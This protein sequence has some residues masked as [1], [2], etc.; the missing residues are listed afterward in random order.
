MWASTASAVTVDWTFVGNPGNA[1]D[2]QSTGCHGA[3]SYPYF[4]ATY[5]VT[6]AQYAE[7]LN[8]KA[9][10]DPLGLY[11]TQM[12]TAFGGIARTGSAGSYSYAAIPGRE[13]KPVLYITFFDA[14]RFANWLN[15]GQGNASTETGGYTLLSGTPTPGN[16][17]FVQRNVG[18]A[19]IYIASEDE[20]YKA[21]YH[22][23]LGLAETDYFN[24][25]AGSDTRT[26]CAFPPQPGPNTA[27]CWDEVN[28]EFD[29]VDVGS[30]E[31]P[32]PYGTYD[33]GGNAREWNDTR[34]STAGPAGL[35]GARGGSYG[36]VANQLSASAPSGASA[37]SEL[38]IG[39]IRLVNLPEPGTH[40][41]LAI[42]L[43]GLL[44]RRATSRN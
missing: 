39:G 11:D 12:G 34:I 44:A 28:E 8:A 6:N 17:Q 13:Q 36:G 16:A 10:S 33:Q 29:V 18:V 41:P 37:E 20:W 27:D 23:S 35:R 1:C 31:A 38:P 15:N 25:P 40:L 9:A 42:A 21:A 19:T 7:F 43:L 32:S 14:L 5:E 2:P 22:D 4:I 26:T 24:Y 3:V 30:Y